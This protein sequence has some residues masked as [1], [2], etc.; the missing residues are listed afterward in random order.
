MRKRVALGVAIALLAACA[1][2]AVPAQASQDPNP[3]WPQLLPP[4]NLS[5]RTQPGPVAHCRRAT[6]R[7]FDGNIRRMRRLEARL[8]C[9]HRAVFA[10]TYLLLTEQIR[11]TIRRD[12]HFFS[13]LRWLT[14][15][16]TVFA[17]YYFRAV[18]A[19]DRGGAVPEAWRIAFD[20]ARSGDAN[21]GQDMLLGINAHV[22]RDMP[23]VVATVGM[24]KRNGDTRKPDHDVVNGILSDAYEP[25]VSAV[26][27][28]Y[29]SLVTISNASWNPVDDVAGLEMVKGWREGVW[30]NAERLVEAK[31]AKQRQRVID[32]IETNAATWAR[33]IAANQLPPG[34]RVQRDLYCAKQAAAR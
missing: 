12:R 33:L 2:A 23:F 20:T 10:T 14:Y 4:R 3:P 24:R 18:A 13:D 19:Y 8:G 29:D 1:P 9:D 21:G 28:R 26:G 22:Q 34:Y 16:D 30:R 11:D 25:I 32:S 7:C 6:M 17:N 15:E 27:Q 31:T 5:D